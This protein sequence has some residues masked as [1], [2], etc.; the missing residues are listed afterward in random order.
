VLIIS[1][2]GT[3]ILLRPDDAQD[4]E[5][6]PSIIGEDRGE[7]PTATNGNRA[8]SRSNTEG[9]QLSEFKDAEYVD[10]TIA[11]KAPTSALDHAQPV[12]FHE[13]ALS[14]VEKAN[15]LQA[16]WVFLN[17][18]PSEVLAKAMELG[19]VELVRA[20]RDFDDNEYVTQGWI[21]YE[22][23]DGQIP[24]VICLSQTKTIIDW[25]YCQEETRPQ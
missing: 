5:V 16:P 12:G 11:P 20:D 6:A 9:G 7:T 4:V 18:S 13:I 19:R 10:G 23:L 22:P 3:L 2:V 25:M 21:Y 14:D 24:V 1:I 8:D 15:L 17:D